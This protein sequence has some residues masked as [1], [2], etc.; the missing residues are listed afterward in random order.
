MLTLKRHRGLG[1]L[2][3]LTIPVSILGAQQP[4]APKTVKISSCQNCS[5][6]ASKSLQSCTAAGGG[7][8]QALACQNS[9]KKRMAHC[10]KKWCTPKTTK[11]KV[12]TPS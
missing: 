11:V 3:L 6:K 12:A 4:T 2:F 8:S 1:L 7:N 10:N 9:Y 5:T